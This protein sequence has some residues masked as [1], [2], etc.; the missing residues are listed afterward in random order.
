M[1]DHPATMSYDEL[2]SMPSKEI[3]R[4]LECI[5]NEVGGDLMSNGHWTGVPLADLLH[6]VGA[7]ADATLVHFTCADGYTESMAMGKALDGS[8]LLVFALDGLPIPT[9]H[10][11]PI[12]VLG[13]GTYGMKNPK[14]LTRIEV[15]RTADPGFW[16]RQ[17][18]NPDA[19]VQTMARID[20]PTAGTRV[21]G[22]V[23]VA[24]VAF[25]GDRGIQK[26]EV[27]SDVGATWT[28][29]T[30]ASPI[31]PTTWTFWQTTWQPRVPG[32]YQIVVRATDETG[33]P[34]VSQN[35]DTFP[36]GSTG[37][38]QIRVEVTA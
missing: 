17:G 29:A 37:Y 23:I 30:L 25:A 5:S 19:I 9:K 15:A 4:T 32:T 11:F 1:V 27:S 2:K 38:H 12:R 31:S 21:S 35:A 8:T 22:N 7:Q 10:G 6:K 14:W 16:E 34:Q 26:V 24:G 33:R 13:T 36:V 20:V 3:D 28:P 18:W